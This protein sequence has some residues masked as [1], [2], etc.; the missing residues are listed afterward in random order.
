LP[1]VLRE[2]SERLVK[3]VVMAQEG[4]PLQ[5][6]QELLEGALQTE[7]SLLL[8]IARHFLLELKIRSRRYR[9]D[10]ESGRAK[11]TSLHTLKGHTAIEVSVEL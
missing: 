11:K 5:W 2:H 10:L 1:V 9:K 3:V 7:G 6:K 4:E 8:W